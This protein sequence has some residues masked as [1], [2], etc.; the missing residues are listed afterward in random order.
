MTWKYK[1]GRSPSRCPTC[2]RAMHGRVLG[3]VDFEKKICRCGRPWNG[4]AEYRLRNWV[5]TRKVAYEHEEANKAANEIGM[6]NRGVMRPY[7]CYWGDHYHV[8]RAVK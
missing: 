5:C 2:K 8:G 3:K 6:D 1:P 7:H 4:L